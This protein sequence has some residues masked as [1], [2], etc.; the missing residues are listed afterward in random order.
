MVNPAADMIEDVDFPRR[1]LSERNRTQQGLGEFSLFGR[2]FAVV[3]K[4]P[5]FARVI[6]AV[7][8][9]SFEFFQAAAVIYVPAGYR[10]RFG[11]RV[12]NKRR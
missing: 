12:L 2:L 7:D 10:A 8:V 5:D 1:V 6:V 11:M 3:S 4:R 9:G